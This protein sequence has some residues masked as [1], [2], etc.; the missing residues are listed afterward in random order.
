MGETRNIIASLEEFDGPKRPAGAYSFNA[1]IPDDYSG[2]ALV[3]E[4][5]RVG[6][7]AH[8]HVSS[9]SAHPDPR[10]NEGAYVHRGIAGKL[11]LRWREWLLLR[12]ILDADSRVRIVEVE[13]PTDGMARR[14][15]TDRPMSHHPV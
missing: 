1:T 10:H 8:V 7:H 2:D 4:A 13:C 5:V 15:M 3:F 11:T 9:G 6:D 12:E 14:Y